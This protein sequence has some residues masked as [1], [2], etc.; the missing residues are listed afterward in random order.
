MDLFLALGQLALG[1][2]LLIGGAE[3]FTEQAVKAARALRITTLAMGLLFAGA[4]PEELFTAGIASWRNAPGLALG[5]VVGTNVTIIA[6]ALG[7]AALI[8]PIGADRGVRRHGA[9]T[10]LVALP[11]LAFLLWGR[12][13]LWGGIVLALLYFGYIFHIIYRERLPL[14]MAEMS[15]EKVA[16]GLANPTGITKR[17]NFLAV[18]LVVISLAVMGGGGHFTVEGARDLARWLNITESSIGLSIVAFATAAEMLFL[19][20]V[21]AL[22]GHPEISLGGILGSYAYNATLTL[23]VAALVR[24]LLAPEPRLIAVSSLFMVG[25]LALLLL[26]IWRGRLGRLDGVALVL[27]Y[28]AY[29]ATVFVL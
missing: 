25:L 27:L 7:L 2:A 5:D 28:G 22:K 17:E 4:E 15:S 11:A 9:I 18:A 24:P 13:P 1:L 6:L 19:A 12:V 21:P 23:G 20:V 3:L 8:L 29:L 10:L 26:M 14:E 16:A